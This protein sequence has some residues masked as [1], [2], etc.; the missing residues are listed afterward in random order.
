MQSENGIL[1]LEKKIINKSININKRSLGVNYNCTL[2]KKEK[3][4]QKLENNTTCIESS[5]FLL[6]TF[7]SHYLL[8]E[9]KTRRGRDRMVDLLMIFFSMRIFSY[10]LQTFDILHS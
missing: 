1:L 3:K 2:S 6:F 4:K 10:Y 7:H 8:Y 5:L 9:K